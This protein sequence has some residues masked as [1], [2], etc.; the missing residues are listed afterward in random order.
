M[1]FFEI[2]RIIFQ[3]YI[4]LFF[5]PDDLLF[6]TDRISSI[7]SHSVMR[8]GHD[9]IAGAIAVFLAFEYGVQSAVVLSFTEQFF[10][11][12]KLIDK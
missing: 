9:Y 12:D 7:C 5:E 4:S 6:F 2:C 3:R 8:F 1:E 11:I 10:E